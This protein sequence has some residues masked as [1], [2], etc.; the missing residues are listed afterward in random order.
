MIQGC[1]LLLVIRNEIELKKVVFGFALDV[2]LGF[3]VVGC[4]QAIDRQASQSPGALI[5]RHQ[6]RI[7]D[8]LCILRLHFFHFGNS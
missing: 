1:D 6:H 3:V 8:K 7:S 4:D 5:Q 2:V